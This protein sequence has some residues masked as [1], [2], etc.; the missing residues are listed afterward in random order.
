MHNSQDRIPKGAEAGEY[1]HTVG[2]YLLG[3][4]LG[5]MMDKC[6]FIIGHSLTEHNILTIQC[7]QMLCIIVGFGGRKY[8]QNTED[9]TIRFSQHFPYFM[10]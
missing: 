10:K 9:Y 3:L 6:H 1:V 2:N 5:Q 7:I 8:R 4:F